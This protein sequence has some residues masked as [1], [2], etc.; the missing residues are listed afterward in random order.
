MTDLNIQLEPMHA[1]ATPDIAPVA[2][3]DFGALIVP[4]SSGLLLWTSGS[5]DP[6]GKKYPGVLWTTGANGKTIPRPIPPNTGK[7]SRFVLRHDSWR[8]CARLGQR[9]RD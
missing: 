1:Q 3:E 5:A 2:P 6:A 4:G 7:R 8:G 9:N